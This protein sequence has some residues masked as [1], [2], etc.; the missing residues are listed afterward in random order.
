VERV[1]TVLLG[2]YKLIDLGQIQLI[3][4]LEKYGYA[5]VAPEAL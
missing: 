2:K 3:L 4:G 5:T 1:E